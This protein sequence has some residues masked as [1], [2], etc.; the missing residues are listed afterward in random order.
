MPRIEESPETQKVSPLARLR[1][2]L[3]QLVLIDSLE[4]DG[5]LT[6]ETAMCYRLHVLRGGSVFGFPVDG[7]NAPQFVK[8]WKQTERALRLDAS[9]QRLSARTERA[10]HLPDPSVRKRG[11]ARAPRRRS[12]RTAGAQARSPGS[13]NDD[14]PAGP[15]LTAVPRWGAA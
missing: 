3:H 2:Q 7:A 10:R 6:V 4:E 5:V 14:D 12:V 1:E 9:R 13:S 11:S 8:R 15:P